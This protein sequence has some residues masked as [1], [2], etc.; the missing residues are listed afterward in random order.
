MPATT[1]HAPTHTN[2][3]KPNANTSNVERKL[4]K[5][6]REIERLQ[7]RDEATLDDAQRKKISEKDTVVAQLAAF[8]RTAATTNRRRSR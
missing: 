1:L 3:T 2:T 4:Q 5:R 6:L 7:Q 8:A